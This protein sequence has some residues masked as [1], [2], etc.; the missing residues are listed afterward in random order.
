MTEPEMRGVRLGDVFRDKEG[1]LWEVVALCDQPQA[2]VRNVTSGDKEQHVIGCLNW[3]TKWAA[4]PLREQQH[5]STESE[6]PS[7]AGPVSEQE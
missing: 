7:G 2:T 1:A 4:G 3:D 5:H 6:A